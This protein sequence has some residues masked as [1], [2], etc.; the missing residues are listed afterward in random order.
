MSPERSARR[1][2]W[3]AVLA[4]TLL[5]GVFPIASPAPAAAAEPPIAVAVAG[6]EVLAVEA[7]A[8]HTCAIRTDGTLTCWGYERRRPGNRARRD[9]HRRE[10]RLV[11]HLRD[12]D[13]RDA[14]LLGL[15]PGRPDG[16]AQRDVQRRWPLAVATPA[17]SPMTGRLPA[18]AYNDYGQA[19]PPDGVFDAVATGAA[20]ACAIGADGTLACWGDDEYGQATAPAGTFSAVSAG[21]SHTC[22]IRTDGTLA[23]WGDD[24]YGQA[25]PPA[26]TFTDVSAGGA[27]TCAIAHRRD[28]RLLGRQRGG[29]PRPARRDLQRRERRRS[30][31]RA[32]CAPTEP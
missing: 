8:W 30:A 17:P 2:V 22:A 12:P 31:I 10:R 5:V 21:W 18:G 20:H 26:G 1:V 25:T 28:P 6:P 9:V 27:H 32:R 24:E 23:C 13:R 16:R 11:A 14:D 3:A 15:W 4:F 7:G 29:L 19:T